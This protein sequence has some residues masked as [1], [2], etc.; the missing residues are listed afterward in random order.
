MSTQLKTKI[1]VC[2]PAFNEARTISD[3]ITKSK[4]YADAIIVYDEGSTDTTYEVA[5][6]AG[7]TV[8][9]NPEN[10][11]YGIAIG[12]IVGLDNTLANTGKVNLAC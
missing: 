3:I 10:K 1:L 11:G 9:R 2:V 12:G 8:I 5:L 7:A 4:R 6:G